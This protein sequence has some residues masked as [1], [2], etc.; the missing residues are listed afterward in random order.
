VSD[1]GSTTN[2]AAYVRHMTNTS[3]VFD[4]TT[5]PTLADV[6]IFLDEI[7]AQLNGWLASAGYVIPVTAVSAKL[8]LD[9]YANIGA[10]GMCELTMR[11]AGYSK[12]DQ[13]KRENKLM[14]E[15]YKAELFIRS[16]TLNSMGAATNQLPSGA[17]GLKFGG[18]TAGGNGL[19]PTFTRRSFGND[20]TAESGPI[21]PE[22]DVT[23]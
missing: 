21:T 6:T 9:R 5:K 10:A 22:P 13:N 15:F 7:C 12:D 11:S 14:Q 1:Y 16:G 23:A 4:T 20:P 8:V 2:V 17:F 3:G 19:R 18:R